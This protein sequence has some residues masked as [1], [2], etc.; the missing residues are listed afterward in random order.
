M[1]TPIQKNTDAAIIA[2]TL[3]MLSAFSSI[4]CTVTEI[5]ELLEPELWVEQNE[6]TKKFLE[7][8]RSWLKDGGRPNFESLE[9]ELPYFY[10]IRDCTDLGLM[11]G[12]WEL[13][14]KKC[15][16]AIAALESGQDADELINEI[17]SFFT[18]APTSIE[19]YKKIYVSN[20]PTKNQNDQMKID[21]GQLQETF[22]SKAPYMPPDLVN[23]ELEV[24]NQIIK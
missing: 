23:A 6:P 12:L 15:S 19:D 3:R 13:M 2:V 5:L 21:I 7:Q 1:T 4:G 17:R 16:Q 20:H 11:A 22:R 9:N 10:L 14:W 8:L 18:S 24:W